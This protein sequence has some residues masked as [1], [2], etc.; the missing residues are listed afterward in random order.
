MKHIIK[1]QHRTTEDQ[2]GVFFSFEENGRVVFVSDLRENRTYQVSSTTGA[3]VSPHPIYL[4]SPGSQ[5]YLLSFIPDPDSLSAGTFENASRIACG[6]IASTGIGSQ[7]YYVADICGNHY[8]CYLWAVGTAPCVMFYKNDLLIAMLVMDKLSYRQMYS[9]TIHI[10]EDED[11]P[12]LC[13]LGLVCHHLQWAYELNNNFRRIRGQNTRGIAFRENEVNY[14]FEIPV[15]GIGKS[16]YN[17]EFL[18]Q[19]YPLDGFPYDDGPVTGKMAVKEF[20]HGLKEATGTAWTTRN[21]KSSLKNP[22]S[23]ILIIG[24]PILCGIIM[25]FV[26]WSHLHTVVGFLIGLLGTFLLL[27]VVEVIFLLF[28]YLLTKIFGKNQ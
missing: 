26:A 10:E 17:I 21:L 4:F 20:G 24:T 11:L 28:F 8:E 12:V 13:L 25:G 9:M 22:V 3:P 27:A 6:S 18:K 1:M 15:Y 16:K 14:H 19:F 2:K 5:Q 23:L 7:K